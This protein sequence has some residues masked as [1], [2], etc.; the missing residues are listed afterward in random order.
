MRPKSK[1]AVPVRILMLAGILASGTIRVVRAGEQPEPARSG[2][3]GILASSERHKFEVFFYPTGVKVFPASTAGTPIEVTKLTGT[4]TFYH[5]NSPNPW[6]SRQLHVSAGPGQ[7]PASLDLVIGLSNV[8]KEGGKVRFEISGLEDAAEST[9]R[10]TVP[11]EFV[12]APARVE[13]ERPTAP[14]GDVPTVPRYEYRPG[15]YG[16]GYYPHSENASPNTGYSS[17]ISSSVPSTHDS[18]IGARSTRDY[19]TGRDTPIA[20]PWLRPMD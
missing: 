17:S 4:A 3:G 13:A 6:F 8:P 7:S 5:P 2:R 1:F 20:K 11:L 19:S 10:F 16:Y 12:P 9:A 18:Y 15:Y 14:R